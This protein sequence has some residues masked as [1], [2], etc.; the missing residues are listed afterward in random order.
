MEISDG[1]K[2]IIGTVVT[3]IG[4]LGS[5]L[6]I[7]TYIESSRKRRNE[8][9]DQDRED[10]KTNRAKEIDFDQYAFKE[11]TERVKKLEIKVEEL[12]EKLNS[13]I[14]QNAELKAENRYLKEIHA[15]QKEEILLLRQKENDL[16]SQVSRLSGMVESLQREIEILKSRSD[17][18]MLQNRD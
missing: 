1:L 15:T 13:Q 12:Q 10:K 2:W 8:L 7:N 6:G 16:K 5:A 3:L 11:F 4:V 18:A 14:L 9:E 17:S